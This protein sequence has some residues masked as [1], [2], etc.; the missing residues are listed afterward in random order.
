MQILMIIIGK[1]YMSGRFDLSIQQ[2]VSPSLFTIFSSESQ[3]PG[4]YRR[5]VPLSLKNMI[6]ERNQWHK[7]VKSFVSWKQL[8]LSSAN[9]RFAF[10]KTL[11][12]SINK[13]SHIKIIQ[14]QGK[15]NTKIVQQDHLE[16]NTTKYIPENIAITGHSELWIAVDVHSLSELKE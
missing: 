11:F 12:N 1:A 7:T 8:N 16:I 2:V 3:T 6:K 14:K 13:S 4:N 15:R 10:G 9:L 5:K